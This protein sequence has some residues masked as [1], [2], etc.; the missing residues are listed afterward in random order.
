MQTGGEQIGAEDLEGILTGPLQKGYV[1]LRV[2]VT[3]L[4]QKNLLSNAH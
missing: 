3:R 4:H 2:G 1:V